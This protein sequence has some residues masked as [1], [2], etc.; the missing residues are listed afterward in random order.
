MNVRGIL[1]LLFAASLAT[2]CGSAEFGD[3]S[4]DLQA[5]ES[6]DL[7][8]SDL[9]NSE[10]RSQMNCH[11]SGTIIVCTTDGGSTVCFNM[12]GQKVSCP[13]PTL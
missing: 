7:D 13:R 6:P 2:G 9:A 10:I 12:Q 3:T 5:I 4:D 8:V 11:R 1:I